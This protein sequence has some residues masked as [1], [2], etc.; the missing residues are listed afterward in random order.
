MSGP[1]LDLHGV[2]LTLT[3]PGRP[4]KRILR[5]VDLRVEPGES[6][7]LVGASGSGKSTLL[8]I[9]GLLLPPTAGTYVLG[10]RDVTG[11]RGRSAAALRSQT[12]GFV[13]QSYSLLEDLTVA[14]NVEVPL[15]Y[16]VAPTPTVRRETV[17]RALA[18]V[19]LA[20]Y[21]TARPPELSGGEQQRVAVA[22]G[23]IRDPR[24]ILADEPTGALDPRTG[25]QVLDLLEDRVRSSGASLVMVTHDEMVAERMD[26]R[27]RLHDG[28]LH[29]TVVA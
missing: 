23:L 18:D 21:E 7:A 10:G 5:G 26:R 3:P 29:E 19:G 6:I 12:L 27:L 17:A 13:F 1:A 15:L 8:S 11:L 28:V 2:E 20:G 14:E 22:R 16:G 4:T 25:A 9:L 24:V